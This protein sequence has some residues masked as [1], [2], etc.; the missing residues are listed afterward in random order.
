MRI[1]NSRSNQRLKARLA[2]PDNGV[3]RQAAPWLLTGLLT[4]LSSEL[5]GELSL[6]ALDQETIQRRRWGPALMKISSTRFLNTSMS[7][8]K[9][10]PHWCVVVREPQAT[11]LI[12]VI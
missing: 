5:P 10:A 9:T 3:L 1:W 2:L 6:C 4:S 8:V 11:V 7:D 12:K